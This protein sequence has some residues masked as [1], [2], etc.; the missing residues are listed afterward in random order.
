M[1]PALLVQGQEAVGCEGF[2]AAQAQESQG[3]LYR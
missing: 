3:L 1:E 2:T